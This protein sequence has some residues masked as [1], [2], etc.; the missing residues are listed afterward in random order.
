M[1]PLLINFLS[2]YRLSPLQ[3]APNVFRIVMSTAL[4]NKKLGL[5]LTVHD[6]IYVY[7]IQ[8]IGKNQYTLNAR[9]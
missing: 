9:R 6:I 3:C 8:K 1:H 4:L 2:Q 7:K 5:N